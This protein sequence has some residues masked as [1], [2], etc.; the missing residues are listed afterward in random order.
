MNESVL[1]CS[2]KT[3]KPTGAIQPTSAF[4]SKPPQCESARVTM[5]DFWIQHGWYKPMHDGSKKLIR[6]DWNQD[7][8]IRKDAV[9]FLVGKVLRKDHR[10][11]VL[12]DFESNRLRGLLRGYYNSSPDS[13]L[14]E[15]GYA[16]HPWELLKS[17]QGFFESKENRIDATRW[18]VGKLK[19]KPRDTA[20]GDFYSN[21]L[22][23]LISYHGGSPY[24]ALLEAGLVTKADEAHMRS[25]AHKKA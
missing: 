7:P 15:A 5:A 21:R 9:R 24:R 2:P 25:P 18:L 8:G 20:V 1:G 4:R 23:G 22:C 19:K 12:E 6:A 3:S 14:K 11:V 17:P 10:D 13:A 16:L